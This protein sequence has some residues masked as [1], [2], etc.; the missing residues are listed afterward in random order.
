MLLDRICLAF[1]GSWV[2]IIVGGAVQLYCFNRALAIVDTRIESVD[3]SSVGGVADSNQ[4]A[5]D[6]LCFEFRRT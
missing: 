5:H 6:E 2:G 3:S 1:Y 4:H